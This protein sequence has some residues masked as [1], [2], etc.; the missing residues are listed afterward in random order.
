MDY[1]Y[2]K[3]INDTITY[4]TENVRSEFDTNSCIYLFT[5]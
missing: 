5:T 3:S 2:V 1:R 4:Y